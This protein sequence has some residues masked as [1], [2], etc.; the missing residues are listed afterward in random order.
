MWQSGPLRTK[1]IPA[2]PA[3]QRGLHL[4]HP[5]SSAGCRTVAARPPRRPSGRRATSRR[6][7]LARLAPG[8]PRPPPVALAW[9][10]RSNPSRYSLPQRSAK[11]RSSAGWSRTRSCPRAVAEEVGQRQA[12][13]APDLLAGVLLQD[14]A[15]ERV[16]LRGEAVGDPLAQRHCID[17][18]LLGW[19]SPTNAF[20]EVPGATRIGALPHSRRGKPS[21]LRHRDRRKVT[22]DAT[23]S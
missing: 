9:S 13:L 7:S 23:S 1:S 18:A 2:A 16:L 14:R 5:R 22:A 15:E 21:F 3:R 10:R 20:D 4:S 6:R 11:S 8:S 12:G 17:L 19:R